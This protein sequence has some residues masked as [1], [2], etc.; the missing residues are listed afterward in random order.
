MYDTTTEA[1][2]GDAGTAGGRGPFPDDVLGRLLRRVVRCGGFLQPQSHDGVLASVSETMAL[3]EMAAAGTLS[4]RELGDLLAL[5]KSTVSRLVVGMEQRGW[6]TRERD[7]ANR[8]YSRLQLT[9]EGRTAAARIGQELH[10][11]HRALLS[12]MTS[13]EHEALVVG[14]TALA[15][16]LE[17]ALPTGPPTEVPRSTRS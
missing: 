11:R 3:G 14:L 9:D 17:R 1:S 16:V 6:L 10:A 15:R 8:R 2:P 4:Q 13:A 7:P 5:E 12:A